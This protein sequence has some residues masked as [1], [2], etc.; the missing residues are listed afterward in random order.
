MTVL[1]TAASKH[2][3]TAE[4]AAW[5]G[6]GLAASGV[7]AEVRKLE[8]IDDL[9]RYDAFVV[10]SAVYLG[11]WL[12]AARCFVDDHG[13]ELASRP[14]WLFSLGPIVGKPPPRDDSSALR[15]GLVEQLVEKTHARGHTVFGGKLA[16]SNLNWGEKIAVRCAHAS[17]GDFRD[18]AAVDEWAATIARELRQN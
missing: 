7:D 4:L 17:E 14:T 11:Q 1:V 2:G 16:K 8:E 6:A 18:R 3:A 12:K 9:E 15:A 13:G 10:G 5:I